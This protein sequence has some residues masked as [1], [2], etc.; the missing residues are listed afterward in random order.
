MLQVH[1]SFPLWSSAVSPLRS[2]VTHVIL[3]ICCESSLS[4]AHHVIMQAWIYELQ[5]HSHVMLL[6]DCILPT[7]TK[8][9]KEGPVMSLD[10][11][12]DCRKKACIGFF[13]T[14]DTL[15]GRTGCRMH[16]QSWCFTLC[17]CFYSTC[18]TVLKCSPKQNKT[19]YLSK[20]LEHL[21]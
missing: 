8:Y 20:I 18:M 2:E 19:N 10:W 6:Q 3:P 21:L 7:S 11:L 16:T 4:L 15:G 13:K 9:E 1:L 17:I 5:W 12:E 14:W